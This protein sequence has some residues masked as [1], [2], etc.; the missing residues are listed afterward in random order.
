MKKFVA[1]QFPVS[2]IIHQYSTTEKFNKITPDEHDRCL[3]EWNSV[4]YACF[5]S[6]RYSQEESTA[7][8]AVIVGGSSTIL[9]LCLRFLHNGHC[10]QHIICTTFTLDLHL[11]LD[12]TRSSDE[13]EQNNL[14]NME[15]RRNHE[16]QNLRTTPQ[17]LMYCVIT[18]EIQA[19]K[20]I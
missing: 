8:M 9:E 14:I 10:Q 2:F 20:M 6:R 1:K 5:E 3:R 19:G 16:T 18:V 15:L 11:K 7:G 12:L 13:R 17:L 4:C